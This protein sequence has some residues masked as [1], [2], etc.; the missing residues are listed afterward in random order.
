MR[1]SRILDRIPEGG[2][3]E[4]GPEMPAE[5]YGRIMI[6]RLASEY[7]RFAA[8]AVDAV[9]PPPDAAVLEI[10]PGPGWAGI[11]LLERNP[12]FRLVGVDSSADMIRA[13]TV[14]A[15]A[16]GIG[17]RVLYR[18]GTAEALEGVP[19]NSVDLVIS[20]DSLHHWAD[21]RR[22][23]DSILRVLKPKGSLFLRD[24][25][26]DI[27]AGAWAFVWV[28]GTLTMGSLSRYWRSSIRAAYTPRE[29]KDLVP[30]AV[31]REWMIGWGFLDL[32]AV[33]R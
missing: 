21:P 15:A 20:R 22:A 24:E 1:K 23:F 33:F 12:G 9:G 16:R 7:D 10:G 6:G 18:L 17:A 27:S 14:N 8:D 28:F 25:R 13:A 32:T 30:G 19:T 31:G 29:L 26:R 11:R 3:I 4:D 2:A 5:K